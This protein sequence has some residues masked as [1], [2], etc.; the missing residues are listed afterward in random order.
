MQALVT[1]KATNVKYQVSAKKVAGKWIIGG[2]IADY[3]GCH[4]EIIKEDG[5]HYELRNGRM[6]RV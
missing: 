4:Y 1:V 5:S 6:V 2:D 3:K